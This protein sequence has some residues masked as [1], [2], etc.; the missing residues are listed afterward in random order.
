M[1]NVQLYGGFDP[2][3]GIET[4]EDT[5]ILPDVNNLVQGSVLSGDFNGNDNTGNFDNHTENA[6]HVTIVAGEVGSALMDGFTV[7]GGYAAGRTSGPQ[8]FGKTVY[9]FYGGGMYIVSASPKLYNVLWYSNL[10]RGGGGVYNSVALTTDASLPI[11]D[12]VIFHQNRSHSGGGGIRNFVGSLEIRQAIFTNNLAG[13]PEDITSTGP[14]GGIYSSGRGT[15]LKVTNATFYGNGII[16][17]V[18]NA[19]Y[20]GGAIH[21]DQTTTTLSNLIIWG[22][23]VEGDPTARQARWRATAP[24]AP[25]RCPN[26]R[27]RY[28]PPPAHTH[29]PTRVRIAPR[30]RHTSTEW[31]DDP[32]PA[33]S[34]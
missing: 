26:G 18:P 15:S 32:K 8:V 27:R 11:L 13:V 12:K 29:Q 21:L 14:G 1:P 3:A 20:N 16:G 25:P 7:T 6:H 33:I 23:E 19:N 22:N 17:V 30:S 34:H 4:L 31:L 5:R 10:G 28:R 9:R 24:R 2:S